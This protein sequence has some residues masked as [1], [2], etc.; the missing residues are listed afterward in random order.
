MKD[1]MIIPAAGRGSRLHSPLPKLLYP[2]NGRP[3]IDYLFDLYA[4]YV[5]RFI[6]VLPPSFVRQV[7]EHCTGRTLEVEYTIQEK[8]TGMLDALLIPCAMAER[9]EPRSVWIT[10]CDQIAIH[11]ATAA[12]LA[13]LGEHAGEAP[14]IFP[15]ITRP[16]PYIHIARDTYSRIVDILHRREGDPMPP[17]GESDMGLFRLTGLAYLDLLPEF[18]RQSATGNL[19]AERNFLPFIPWLQVRAEVLTFSGY[20]AVESVGVNDAD[21]LRVVEEYL[22]RER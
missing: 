6:L 7:R 4:P 11:P 8:P 18:A 13:E 19:R 9:Y 22:R 1:L 14:L 3:M 17:V 2:V 15:T 21:D 10:W 12:R 5:E 20:D 16:N